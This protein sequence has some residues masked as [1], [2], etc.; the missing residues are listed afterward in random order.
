MH[1]PYLFRQ[2]LRN[3]NSSARTSSELH[4]Q[5]KH[6]NAENSMHKHRV[7]QTYTHSQTEGQPRTHS[8]AIR[9]WLKH[10]VTKFPLFF[11]HRLNQDKAG[12]A[13]CPKEP[14]NYEN[15]GREWIQVNLTQRYVITE[16]ATQGRF[17]NGHGLEFTE[18]YFIEYSRDFGLSWSK[19]KNS[20]GQTVIL[21]SGIC[22]LFFLPLLASLTSSPSRF[23]FYLPK[24]TWCCWKA[25]FFGSYIPTQRAELLAS[26]DCLLSELLTGRDPRIKSAKT[27]VLPN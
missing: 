12:G 10:R 23:M 5:C 3:I 26:S 27:K 16:V 8:L 6:N 19:W 24:L 17:G 21:E 25:T 20:K 18:E 22:F 14:L 11:D 7:R 9:L 13:W 4:E 1:L 15:S 2:H